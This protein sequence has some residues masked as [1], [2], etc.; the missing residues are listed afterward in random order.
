MKS[1]RTLQRSS[2][3]SVSA[4]ACFFGG[5]AAALIGSILTAG[6]WLWRITPH[7]WVHGFGTALLIITIPLL[8]LA[9]HCM[10]W[11]EREQKKQ[12]GAHALGGKA[13]PTS[14]VQS[15]ESGMVETPFNGPAAQELRAEDKGA[16]YRSSNSNRFVASNRRWA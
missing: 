16:A 11:M 13:S 4:L 12:R 9:G 6:G 8:I 3:A 14:N 15:P 2:L 7:P 5:I 1:Q 10:D